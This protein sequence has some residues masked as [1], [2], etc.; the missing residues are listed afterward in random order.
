MTQYAAAF[1]SDWGKDTDTNR[2]VMK[3]KVTLV[4]LAAL[5]LAC[6]QLAEAQ[7][8]K[9][10]SRIGYLAAGDPLVSLPVPRH[11]GWLCAHLAISKD[12]TSLSSTDT[13]G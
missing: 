4:M 8:P 11:F 10:V 2:P 3:K 1:F 5:I 13:R 6:F 7:Q 9:K 12:R